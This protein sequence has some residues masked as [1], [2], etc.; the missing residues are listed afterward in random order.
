MLCGSGGSQ[1]QGPWW[2]NPHFQ[3][4]AIRPWSVTS[5]G[6]REPELQEVE[7]YQLD[8][9]SLTS[10]QILSSETSFL[11]SRWTFFSM[12]ELSQMKGREQVMIY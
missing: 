2:S 12:T 8:I 4:L 3:K 1:R 5:L 11:E 10:M 6:G 7:R 9:A